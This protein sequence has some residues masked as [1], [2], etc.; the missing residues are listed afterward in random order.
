MFRS[1]THLLFSFMITGDLCH[2][3]GVLSRSFDRVLLKVNTL[4]DG[5]P[6]FGVDSRPSGSFDV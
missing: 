6:E 3:H 2:L 4:G 1:S 5:T